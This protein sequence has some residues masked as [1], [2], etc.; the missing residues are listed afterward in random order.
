M[1][2]DIVIVRVGDASVDFSVHKDILFSVSR[3]F[4][5][6]WDRSFLGVKERII[7]LRDVSEATF[8]IFLTWCY[9]QCL[10][11]TNYGDVLAADNAV[12]SNVKKPRNKRLFDEYVSGKSPYLRKMAQEEVDKRFHNNPAWHA[13]YQ[14]VVE[15]LVRL[16]L[17]AQKYSIDQLQDDVMSTYMGYCV[18][19]GLYPDPDDVDII[20]LA[21]ANLPATSPL[22]RYFVLSTVYFWTPVR[23]TLESGKLGRLHKRFILDVMTAQAQRGQPP[24]KGENSATKLVPN[25]ARYGLENSCTFHEHKSTSEQDCRCRMTNSKFIFDSLLDACV[26]EAQLKVSKATRN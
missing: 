6:A 15:S 9:S 20:E 19:Y 22:S 8:R 10:P 4:H 21:Y 25:L 24:N 12:S 11:G 13:T 26:K 3:F 2:S 18:S 17:F 7:T 1:A 5:R 23:A 16:Y 14:E